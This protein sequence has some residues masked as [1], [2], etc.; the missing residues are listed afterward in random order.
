MRVMKIIKKNVLKALYAAL[1]IL[2]PLLAYLQYSWIGELSLQEK[3]SFKA[4]FES[5][6][7]KFSLRISDDFRMISEGFFI[8]N[9][10][11]DSV[12]KQITES[13]RNLRAGNYSGS[14]SRVYYAETNG[15]T[16]FYEYDE[17]EGILVKKPDTLKNEQLVK[18]G[19]IFQDRRRH[20]MP[21]F[22]AGNFE[23]I[24]LFPFPP[25]ESEA[26][27]ILQLNQEEVLD[28]IVL[29]NFLSIFP[30]NLNNKIAL[31][32]VNSDDSVIFSNNSLYQ[33]VEKADVIIP[34]GFIG[35]FRP[36]EPGRSQRNG[37]PPVIR[38]KPAPLLFSSKDIR[39]PARNMPLL[40]KAGFKPHQL[41]AM[42]D[43]IR[44]KNLAISFSILILLTIVIILIAVNLSGSQSLANR[45]LQFVAGISHELRTPLSVIRS[46]AQN[47]SD[48]IISSDE[49]SLSYGKLIL[50]EA[51]KLWEMIE[52]TLSYAGVHTDVPMLN[53]RE[54]NLN[55]LI[56]KAAESV[57]NDADSMKA[58]IKI[59]N[60]FPGILIR[61]N[62]QMLMSVFRNIISNS[63]K[64]SEKHLQITIKTDIIEKEGRVLIKVSDNGP[65]IPADE[66][67]K[68][69]KPFF[70]GRQS[71]EKNIPGNGVGL[72]LVQKAAELHKG[73]FRIESTEGKGTEVII[74]LPIISL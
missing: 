11:R 2:V 22:I 25:D 40:L 46:A 52:T 35:P 71:T 60:E 43:E 72:A 37:N 30:E 55:N 16:H 44:F 3:E 31:N 34:L 33:K 21:G 65:G 64:F 51:D 5:D 66:L 41:D 69:A 24:L 8:R 28:G 12:L 38:K 42:V 27:V 36:D 61:A 48:G 54:I 50:N 73:K 68:V 59:E 39:N 56:K 62:E 32:I 45:Q 67:T 13:V 19:K 58:V 29:R 15:R 26:A 10:G 4:N 47:L 63:I 53:F 14:V 70:R 23:F 7:L 9:N 18:I 17:N 49:K 6:C 74:E 1:V 57:M 20:R